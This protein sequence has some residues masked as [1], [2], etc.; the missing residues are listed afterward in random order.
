MS[1]LKPSVRGL[2]KSPAFSIVAILTL[3]V[4][5]GAGTA[6]FSAYDRLVLNPV[7]IPH[8]SSLVAIWIKNSDLNFNAP[9]V[10]WPKYQEIRSNARSF[11]SMGISAG[12]NFTLTGAGDPVQLNGLRVS[13]TFLPTLGIGP[14]MGRNFAESEDVPN[15]AAVC[16]VSDELW[17]T[18]FG[19][20]P[21]MIGETIRLNGQPWQVIGIMP[22][23][24]TAPFNQVDILA[25]RVFEVNGLTQ[26]QVQGGAGYA[27][28]IARLKAGVSL[29]QANSELAVI[30]RDYKSRFASRLDANN[31]T[32]S[33]RYVEALVANLAPTFNALLA[34][35]AFVL[36]IACANVAALFL[37][38]LTARRK[39]IALRQSIGATRL[40]IVTQFLTE[41]LVFSA[42]SAMAG[43]LMAWW[44]LR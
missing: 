22:P 16:I 3:G 41:S 25:P 18:Q 44:A 10:S 34:A 36:L 23:H 15:G 39:E 33:R 19:G 43:S 7:T 2:M 42:A 21:G 5:M 31:S 29:G 37:S 8:P 12:D 13:A 35:V 14:A 9:A 11:D 26:P 4:A 38:R 1:Y 27:Q 17:R 40:Q 20:R 32:E 28:A 24:L 30:D 6:V